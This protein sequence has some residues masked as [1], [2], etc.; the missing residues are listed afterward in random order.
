MTLDAL[1]LD[2]DGTLAEIVERPDAVAVDPALPGQ[3]AALRDRFGGALALV[4][5]RAVATL[6]GFLAP[7]RGDAAGLHGVERRVGGRFFGCEPDAH[8]ALRAGV[9]QLKLAVAAW[10]GVI[11]EDKG[12]SVALHWRLAPDH[13]AESHALMLRLADT[14]GADYRLQAGKAV[15]EIL[16]ASA[17]KGGVIA[18]LMEEAPYRGRRPVFVGDDLTDEDGFAVVNAMG[19]LSVRVGAGETIAAV[20]LESPAAVRAALPRWI[21]RGFVDLAPP[22]AA[23]SSSAA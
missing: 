11:V 4:S 22:Q 14:L 1:F 23:T 17:G 5:G 15:A 13:A 3:L 21:E 18:R 8:P 16:P 2:F 6:D 7:Y 20:R 10:E 19:G 12:C 9:A